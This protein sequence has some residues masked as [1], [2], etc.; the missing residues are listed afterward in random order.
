MANF[1]GSYSCCLSPPSGCCWAAGA[2]RAQRRDPAASRYPLEGA[3]CQGL[4]RGCFS[5]ARGEIKNKRAAGAG[6]VRDSSGPSW[7]P[8]RIPTSPR[9]SSSP[10]ALT[11]TCWFSQPGSAVG[12]WLLLCPSPGQTPPAPCYG[13]AL[14]VASEL[15]LGTRSLLGHP[16]CDSGEFLS[17]SK[18]CQLLQSPCSTPAFPV[19]PGRSSTDIQG[20][21]HTR[22]PGPGHWDRTEN[23][24]WI[25]IFSPTIH[26]ISQATHRFF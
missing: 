3:L 22:S 23:S 16:W 15:C 8:G 20:S 11:P 9:T 24:P 5:A 19:V 21:A 4:R 10:P 13:R 1:A 18:A 17:C 26:F 14:S 7:A 6:S 12:Q 2:A 25:K